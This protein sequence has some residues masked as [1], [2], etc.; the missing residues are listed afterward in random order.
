MLY[1]G[2]LRG[3]VERY[4]PHKTITLHFERPV[5]IGDLERYGEVA[6]IDDLQFK[7]KTAKDAAPGAT[8]RLLA[9]LPVADL[10]VED[11]ALEDVI[12]QVFRT[13]AE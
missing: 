7:V 9:D 10:S 6:R 4:A 3:L 5:D 1:D 8:A 2:L 13:A 12:D 11:P